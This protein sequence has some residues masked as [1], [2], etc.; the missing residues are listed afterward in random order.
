MAASQY[1]IN[2]HNKDILSHV[3]HASAYELAMEIK[4]MFSMKIQNALI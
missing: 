4:I 2:V 3:N 1:K